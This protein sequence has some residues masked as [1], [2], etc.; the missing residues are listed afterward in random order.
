MNQVKSKKDP[1]PI[2]RISQKIIGKKVNMGDFIH[3]VDKEIY[4]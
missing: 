3:G 2:K 4:C 1:T